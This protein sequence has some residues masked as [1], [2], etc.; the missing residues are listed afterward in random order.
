[1]D[2]YDTLINE[3]NTSDSTVLISEDKMSATLTLSKPSFGEEYTLKDLKIMLA[4]NN[5]KY[6]VDEEVLQRMID[7]SIYNNPV[8]V[9]LGREPV[10]GKDGYY[11]YNFRTEASSTPRILEDGS[12]DYKNMD[13]FESVTSGQVVAEYI[14]ATSGAAGYTVNGEIRLATPGKDLPP[15]RGQGFTVS[16]DKSQYI[17]VINGRIELSSDGKLL[18]SNVYTV[19]G[20]LDIS[21]GNV[22]FDGDVYVMGKM[23]SGLSIIAKGNVVIDGHVGNVII[24]SGGDVVLKNGMQCSDRGYIECGGN[25]SGRFFEAAKIK[26]QGDV[27]ANYFFNCDISSEGKITVSGNKGLI[28]GGSA[29]AVLGIEA[30]GLGNMAEV[31]TKISVGVTSE[32]SNRFATVTQKLE[33]VDEEINKLKKNISM[34]QA[35]INRGKKKDLKDQLLFAKL[36]QALVMKEKEKAQYFNEQNKLNRLMGT[37][38]KA[39]VEVNGRTFRG[40]QLTIDNVHYSVPDTIS[41][42]KFVRDGNAIIT[43]V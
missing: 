3:L 35:A 19:T 42:V 2:N 11:V 36:K 6:G 9:A 25:V 29:Q 26:A 41:N 5:V 38:G 16:E 31:P 40:V 23:R 30:H 15:L 34:F 22:R 32:I 21:V 4:H 18:I 14:K 39:I 28:I 43:K 33:D 27:N 24:R 7:M 1:M 12:V 10:N 17:S 20:D 13:L 8:V 37:T